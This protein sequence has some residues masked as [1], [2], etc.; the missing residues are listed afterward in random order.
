MLYKQ[1]F[2]EGHILMPDELHTQMTRHRKSSLSLISTAQAFF[3]HNIEKQTTTGL[4]LFFL[5]NFLY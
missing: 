1:S 4:F 3:L 2:L 5:C